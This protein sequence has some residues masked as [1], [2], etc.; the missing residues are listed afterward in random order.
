MRQVPLIAPSILAADLGNLHADI[1]A[2]QEAGADLLHIDVMDGNFVPPI[3]F[4]ANIVST[5]KSLTDLTL[6]VHLMTLEPRRHFKSMA[7][8]GAQRILIH[9][10]TCPHLHYDLTIL[11]NMGI[12]AGVV[13]NPATPISTIEPI[14]PLCSVVL[15]MTVNPGWGGQKLISSTL[16]KVQELRHMIDREN[17]NALI[18]VD[19]GVNAD[20]AASCRDA[21]ADI[22]VAGSYFYSAPCRSQAVK[23]LKGL[24]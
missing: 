14:L 5:C 17:L 2:G 8:A 23:I 16:R 1:L 20:T 3:S 10:E 12:A 18:E 11:H 19:G 22:L 24:Q 6:E 15:V 4:G 7:E 13:I 9:Q 21:G